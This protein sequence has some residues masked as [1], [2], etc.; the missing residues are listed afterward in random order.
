MFEA[1][2]LISVIVVV[3]TDLSGFVDDGLT[4]LFRRWFGIGTPS[5]I[6]TC[7]L[8]QTHWL[9]LLYLLVTGQWTLASYALLLVIAFLTPVT[10]SI[11]WFIRDFLQRMID[12]VSNYFGL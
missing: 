4:P 6:F 12:A 5:K 7:S 1:L 9:G 2:I 8:C 10:G 3:I 11:L